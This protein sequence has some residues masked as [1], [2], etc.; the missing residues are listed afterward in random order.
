MDF[1]WLLQA[2]TWIGFF[3]LLVLE[4]VLGIDNLVFVAI[5]ANKVKPEHR[6]RTRMLG[7]GLA[8]VVRLFMLAGVSFIMSLTADLFRV[9]N[10][11]VSGRDIV[12]LAG[13]LFLLYKATT[14]LHERLESKAHYAQN[15]YSTAAYAT[16]GT[17][18]LQILVL[19]AVFSLDAVLTAVHMVEH[20][21]VAMAAVVVAMGVM[22]WASKP[23]TAF[24]EQHPTVVVLCLGFLLMIG[25]SL[26]A[27]GFHFKIPKGYLYAAIGFSIIIE[28]FNQISMKNRKENTFSGHSWRRRAADSVLGMMGIREDLVAKAAKSGK[29]DEEGVFE[30]NEKNMIRSVFT[31]AERSVQAVM[32]PRPDI[33]RLDI[34]QPYEQQKEQ[35]QTTPFSRLI[36]VGKAGIEEPLGFVAKKDLLNQILN[37]GSLNILDAVKQPLVLPETSTVLTALELFR[38]NSADLALVV[39]EFGAV[40]G[41]LTMKDMMETIAGEFPEEFEREDAPTIQTNDDDSL[42]V[43][44][45]LEY[46]ELAQQINLPPLPDDADF[47]TVGGLIMEEM[48]EIPNVGDFVDYCGRRWTVIEKDGQRIE[49]VKIDSIKAWI[50]GFQAAWNTCQTLSEIKNSTYR[51][52][53]LRPTKKLQ[54]IEF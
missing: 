2:S 8:I 42:T 1:S 18:I 24:V 44:G 52:V 30:A 36:V 34:S 29:A 11:A 45:S 22:I 41:M 37:S 23:L 15:I 25:L 19:D 31:L 12:M 9:G 39:D 51:R 38:K 27:E 46:A 47:H 10:F 13:G 48:Q 7:L 3:T 26:V 50:K 49:R 54:L 33:E 21:I 40:Q 14:E 17:V 32:T 16:A 20:I 5:L 43:D 35:I 28:V 53:G 6:D 4:V